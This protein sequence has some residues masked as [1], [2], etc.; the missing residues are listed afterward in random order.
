M[1]PRVLMALALVVV[2]AG[3]PAVL[4]QTNAQDAAAL[5]G[6]KSQWTNYPLSWNSG[7]PC[8]GGW[9]GIMCTNG[10]VT[11]LRLSSVSLQGTLSGSIGQLGQLTYLD[12]S[13]NINLGGPLPAEIGNLGELTTLIL[14]GCSFTGNI[15]IA[16][17]NLRKLG[18]LALNSNKF[19]GGI[20]SS[21]GVLT[22]LLWLDL[23][24]NQLTGSVPISTSTSPGLDQL[25]FQQEP[26]NW[27]AYWTFQLQYDSHTHAQSQLRLGLRLDRNGF[28]G[29]I[30]A[31]IGSLVKLNE[32]N[33][34][35]NK[36]TGSVPDLS[37]MTNLNVVDL[38][39]NTFDPSVAPSWFTSLTSLAS[40]S[41]VSGSLSGQVPKG[42]F[43][44][45]TLQQV[46]LSNNQFNGTLEI[47]G[48]ISSSLQTVNL[49]DNRI[50]STDTA[51]YKKTLLLA[52]NPFCAEQD[53][54]NRAFCSR[55]LQNASPYSTSM[56]KCG[57][58]Q[59]SDGQNVN[60]ASCSC[61]F[62]YNG[63]MVFRAPFFVDLVSSTPFQLLE[64]TMAA[65]LNL[66]PGSVALS[67][68]HFNSDNYLQVQVKLFP[69][70]G[71]TFNLSELTRIGSSLSNQIYK[72]PAN[73][74]PYFFIADPYAPLAVALGG[75]K[76]KMSTGAIAGIAVAGGVLV[77]ALIFMSLFALRQKRRA[78]ELKER[79]DPFAS[80]A[81]GQKDSGGAPQLKGARF[82]SFDELKICTN[83]FSDNHEIGSGGY[84][85]VY[86]GILGD[87]TRVAIKR[88]DR[89]SMQG[90]VEFKN[91]IELLSR[92]HHR[93]LVS[94]IGFCYEQGEQMLVYEY[95][96][97]G[98]LRENLTGSGTYLDWKKRLR[99]ALGSA[100]GLAYLHELADPPIIHRDIKSTNIL[101]DNNLKAKVADF[102][103]SK[104]VADTEKGHVSTQVKGTLGYLDPEYYMTQQLSEK[105]DVY[106]FGVVMLELLA[107]RCVDES[108]AARPAM[109]AVVKEIE[110]MLQNEP[111]DAGAGEGDSSADPSA[112]EFDRYRGGGGGGG[113][114]AHPYSDVEISRGSYAG[115][116][117]SDYMPY[118]EVKPKMDQRPMF[119]LLLLLLASALAVFCDTNAQD[120]AALQ[121]LTHQWTNYLSS[122]TS[123]DPC[124]SWA[125]VTCS[126]GRVTSLK[127][128]GV[129]LQG[130]LSS[131]IGQ[132]SQLVIL[133]LAGCSFTGEIPKEIGNL[134]QLWFLR[135][136]MNGFEGAIPTNTSKLVKLNEL[137][138][139]NN[140]LTGSMPDLSSMTNLNVVLM[141][142][143][144]LCGQVPKG[145]FTLPQLQQ[146]VLSN[147]RFNGTLEMA[148]SISNQLEIVNLQNNQ[149][150]S[151]NITGYNNTL[152]LV[153]NPL[154]ADQDFSGQPFCSI[155]Q[156]NTAY[157]TS[158]T[159]CSGS[160][161]SDQCPGDQ[162][163][164]P[165]YCSCAYPY[166]GTLFFRAPYFPDV[167][168]REPFRQLEMT[169]WMQ[170]KLH[171][172]SVYLSDIL[173]DGNNNLEIQVKLF[174][175][176]GVT[177]DRSEVARI[178]SVLAMPM[179]KNLRII[180]GAKAAIGSACGLLVIALI[181]MAIFTLRRKRKA[182][183]L[184]ERVDPLDSWEAPQLKGTRFFRV[185]ELKSCTGNFSD[186]H[187]IGSGGYGKVY[188]GMLADGTHVAIKRAQP[189]S[190]QG[191]VEFKNEIE[192][193]SR[194]HHCNLVRLI[195]YCYE[196]GEQMLVYEY[197]SNGTL[198]DNL[199]GKGLP[200][201]LQKRL[202]IALGSARGLT[203]LHEHA[204]PPIIH[205]DVKSTNILL[206]DNLK[207]KVADFG[208]SKLI[209]DTKKSHV[210]TQVK[211][212]LGYLDLEYYMTQKLSEKSDVY[213]FGVV[214]LEL[215]S[216]RQLIENGEYI[217]REVRL[218]INPADDDHYG[219]RGIVDPAI[220]DSTRTAGFRRF[221]QLAM[222][223]MDD[224]T[225]ARPAMGAVV[226][227]IE[228]ILQ[229]EPAR[230][231]ARP[232]HLPPSSR[233]PAV[234]TTC[235]ITC[236]SL[237]SSRPRIDALRG[238]MQQW[239]NY[240][241]SW[242]SGDPCGGG[243]DGVMC[244][245]GR[246]TS[247]D[248]SSNIGLG[249]PLPAEI[250][251]LGQLTTLILA[252]CSFTGAIPKE[253]GN[254]SKLWF[255]ALNSNKFTG[256]IPPSMTNLFYLDL[257]DNQLTGSISISS[258]TSPG[259]D[260]LVQTKH[261]H[262]NKN[263]LT[264]TLTGLFNSKMTLL[265]ILFD[266]NQLS[267]SIP[268]E[269]GGITTLEVVRL[270]RNGFGGAI[271]TNISNLVSLNQLNLASNKLTGSIPDLSSMSKLNVVDLSNNTFD[272]SVAPVWFTTLTS[273]TSVSIASGNLLGQ[274]PKGLFTLPQLQQVVLSKNALNGTLEMTGII[275]KQLR[276][277]NLLNNNIISANTQ[278]YNNTLVAIWPCTKNPTQC[279]SFSCSPSLANPAC[280]L[281]GNPL[282]V[283]QDYSGKPFC[284][285]RQENLIAY[286]TSMTQCSSSAAQCPDGQ[287]LDPGNCGCA[288]SY[289]G[290]M[291]F[292]APSF[293]D[294][295]TG[296]PFQQLEM[297]LSTQLN[298]RPG[299]VYLSDV[300][301]NSDNYLQ[302]QVKLF[303]SSGMSFN[304][305]ELTRIG[306]DL[307]NQTYK[308]PSNFGP[309]FFIADPYAPLSA[310]RGTSR[311]DSEG[312]PQV[313]RPR[314][315]T[316]RE[317]KRCTDN[318]SESKKIGEGA[319]GKV[320]QGTLERQ[321]VAIKRADPERVHGNK[322]LR[323]EIR[324][325]SGVRHRNLVRIIGYCYEQG[326]CCT[327]DEIMLVNEFVSNGTLKQKLTG[328]LHIPY[329]I[330]LKLDETETPPL[331]WEKRLE[332]ALGSAKGL[333]YLHEHAHGV[334]IHRD[335]K[336]EN[337]LL[338]EDLNAKVADFGLSK[339]VASTENAPPTELIM[340]T[341]AYMEPEYK[342]TG[343]L[344][345]KIDVYSFGIVMMELVIKND[346]MRSIL[347]DLP[348][349][350]PN[351][352]M[353]LILSDLPA[354]PSDDHEPHT[355]ILDDIVD[356]A[357]RDVRPTMVAVERRIEDILNSVVRSSTTE[358]MTAGGDTPT[359]EPN[360]EDNGNE[361]NPS[362]EIAR[363]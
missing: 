236:P 105:S 166:K 355:S 100:R 62:S 257:A 306:F 24:D 285:I 357:I 214:M 34:A 116:G 91:E 170:L 109:G 209:D 146:V 232:A 180:M 277:V 220:R 325:L 8:G 93:N 182:K 262:F 206:D 13:F 59:C 274:V 239:R 47:T 176:S 107:M 63:K 337:I 14:A 343:R 347:S 240:P 226:K 282:C 217:V 16:I 317:M 2:A 11:T 237:G 58:A 228:A 43:T 362:N 356:P 328:K 291:V 153:G 279:Y 271:P 48:N 82:F 9:D 319:F 120:A 308:P 29:A 302:V 164:D 25:P 322:H 171:P 169:L 247:L 238:L 345:D 110:A 253:I 245:N 1:E 335:V 183:E 133:I 336:P 60:P 165:G 157:T 349:G 124:D 108:A 31:T 344:S 128:S 99:I 348:N 286:T 360:R 287:S 310:S 193:L 159:Q 190:M 123:G 197:I 104:L 284:S 235:R 64:S 350:V 161:A 241:S 140:K 37:N 300:H 223:C 22:N 155:K 54:N 321:V 326:F 203:Y 113:P 56:E 303:P 28:T 330:L 173:I 122:W 295:T 163:L 254:L 111:D 276:T 304:L 273:L 292:R 103:L 255:L 299:S 250:G 65:K 359:N 318:F 294:V 233:A 315:F 192:L 340:G 259:L 189:D 72:P 52:G 131:S 358:F 309:Y 333:V 290:K 141:A 117:A 30:P 69:T 152:V 261:L 102:G 213:S 51:S 172:G 121:S 57:S 149:I 280:R 256:G 98:T 154:C 252:G 353:R 221:V 314:R 224:S 296:E 177:F 218:A 332:I 263:Q 260:L 249:G 363:D 132:L 354:D 305:S 134:L 210:S 40:V 272:T 301:W 187:E 230:W 268:A 87:G 12:L 114:P 208:L 5:E 283:D 204:D 112:N 346:V 84:G 198:R 147:N 106:S 96:S 258:P 145:L 175:S 10:R 41:I 162:S 222:R 119:L 289:N 55:Q 77:I 26:V 76:S 135:L 4:C 205:R 248:L 266:S 71:V 143:V 67:D 70:S 216:R 89:N 15:P 185:D 196:L 316:I 324:L 17:G 281:V 83:N 95:I 32:L 81:A 130:I 23:A 199:M 158:M 351:N 334:I 66:L 18:F 168:T 127:L 201:N 361:P 126:G 45:P 38:S 234:A 33:L 275:S 49:M 331:D 74:G 6:L 53:P 211:G 61:A 73:F 181:F 36:L 200:L 267:G 298:L 115:D 39:N 307:S 264:G 243:W 148:G 178:G 242:N 320:Y 207:A 80:W 288:S 191:V 246:V 251:N 138:L 101:L 215:I 338:D 137:N 151:R 244:S 352:V 160:A 125:N 174:P 3:V 19:S 50:V 92:V 227:E 184:I 219:L 88:A 278:S 323:S 20:P 68:I 313:D 225:A 79:A 86:R 156:G 94:L 97:N 46:V 265:H 167:T 329:N 75:K 188:K 186:S 341:N 129:N 311:I 270:D 90:A 293:V 150:V 179:A 142:N 229:N 212:T 269:L 136:N 202:R 194:V 44:L 42:L 297:S 339:L 78:K 231:T 118:F 139:A 27:N 144:S 21:I 35:N 342:R 85:K 195:G 7:D 327:P 312:A